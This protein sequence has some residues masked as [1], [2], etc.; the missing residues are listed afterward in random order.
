VGYTIYRYWYPEMFMDASKYILDWRLGA[1]NTVVLIISSFTMVMGVRAAQT[2][3]Q[4]AL[5]NYLILTIL[6]ACIFMGVK[7]VEYSQKIDHGALP[8]A[9]LKGNVGMT[10]WKFH[11]DPELLKEEHWVTVTGLEGLEKGKPV[12]MSMQEAINRHR[13][14]NIFMGFYFTMTG[15]HGFHILVGIGLLLWMYNRSARGHFYPGYFTPVEM[16]GLYWH[17]VDLIWIFLF[18]LFYLIT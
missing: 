1:L 7:Y 4:K 11:L 14:M 16:V 10:E 15:I 13:H 6:C 2:D 5:K 18:P 17:I 9:A 8:R 3:Q 12:R